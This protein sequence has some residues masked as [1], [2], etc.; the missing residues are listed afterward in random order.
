MTKVSIRLLGPFE[1]H[2]DRQAVN[3]RRKTRA[4]LAY[5]AIEGQA[6]S[7]QTLINLFCQEAQDPAASLRLHLS[8]IRRELGRSIL[9]TEDDHV[10]FDIAE[11]QVDAPRFQRQL[12]RDLEAHS[13]STLIE[14]VELYRGDFLEGL[15]LNDSPEFELW[16]L[17]QRAQL[18]RLYDRGVDEI[19][20]RLIAQEQYQ[21]AISWAQEHLPSNALLEAPTARLMWLYARTGQQTTALDLFERYRDLLQEEL[22]VEPTAELRV[23]RT[24]IATHEIGPDQTT[25]SLPQLQPQTEDLRQT[26]EGFVGREAELKT[27]HQAWAATNQGQGGTLLITAVAGGGKTRLVQTFSRSLTQATILSGDCHESAQHLPYTPWIELLE[28][29]LGRMDDDTLLSL[30]P[31]WLDYLLRLLPHLALRLGRV[32]PPPPPT[33]GGDMERLFSAVAECLLRLSTDGSQLI[34]IDNLQWA[35][36]ASLRLFHFIARRV[37]TVEALLIGALRSEEIHHTPALQILLDDL[38]RISSTQLTLSPL[39]PAEIIDLIDQLWPDLPEL[40]QALVSDMLTQ[41]TGG[42]PLFVTEILRELAHSAE[43]PEQLPLPESVRTL[44]QRRVL[45]LPESDQQVLEAIAVLGSPTTP[46]EAQH[47]SARSE[48]ETFNGIDAGLRQGLLISHLEQYP[49][50]YDF[51]HDLIGEAILDQLSQIRRQLL[52]RRAAMVLE[53]G[54]TPA[55]T[56]AYHWH[57]ARDPIQERHYTLLAA[58]Q[59]IAQFA[60][61][62]ALTHLNRTLELTSVEDQAEQYE[63]LLL[64]ESIYDIQGQR[65]AQRQDLAQLESLASQLGPPLRRMMVA[66][67]RAAFQRDTGDFA[68]SIA[69]AQFAVSLAEAE[70]DIPHQARGHLEWGLTLW[71]R[72]DNETAQYHLG[73]AS[74]LSRRAGLIDEETR[75][76]L[77]LGAIYRTWGD[78]EGAIA[79]ME[80]ALTLSRQSGHWQ[81][82]GTALNNL[83]VIATDQGHYAQA[84]AYYREAMAIYRQTGDRW[85]QGKILGNHGGVFIDLGDYAAAEAHITEAAHI[86]EAV[87][88]HRARSHQLTDLSLL[89]HYRGDDET[90][91]ARGHQAL[92]L[93]LAVDEWPGQANAWLKLG[94]AR[95]GLGQVA[96][97]KAA[98]QQALDI[99]RRLEQFTPAMEAVAGLARVALA[100]DDLDRARG[101]AQEIVDYLAE[102]TIQGAWEPFRVYLTGYQVLEAVGDPHARPLLREAYHLLQERAARLENETTRRSFLEKVS[103]HREIMQAFEQM[104]A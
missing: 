98:Y 23:L 102:N 104:E 10:R 101:Y 40:Q 73:Q 78:F 43:I 1:A 11:A 82:E 76:D 96:A 97:A 20:S 100:E 61:A 83:G 79:R 38:H 3:L 14:T 71:R 103:F 60:H 33:D 24:K 21:E 6:Q 30:S 93:A 92:D 56:L 68:G 32:P 91:L 75:S 25:L 63:V 29:H 89:A 44:V 99:E 42:N 85:N 77:T 39:S 16:L 53:R 37:T 80:Q 54:R 87:G 74:Q 59:A 17:G 64:R 13:D 27:L 65:D 55:A 84:D 19:V 58:Q 5:L 12:D 67:R 46:E 41:A 35:D 22:A 52:H 70:Q 81:N 45:G 50:R 2:A 66:L 31:F 4:L 72:G 47:T 88:D 26:D 90:A 36:E 28:T 15:T 57:M 48:D 7:R 34:F 18:R 86:F 69:A 62:D 8:R 51:S 49:T 95:L 94:H 9:L